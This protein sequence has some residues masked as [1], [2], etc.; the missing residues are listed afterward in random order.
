MSNPLTP[1]ETWWHNEGSAM[2]PLPG[3][4]Y[5]QHA[6]RVSAIAWENG[7]FCAAPALRQIY[8]RTEGYADGAPD[9]SPH[10]RLCNEI[11][12]IAIGGARP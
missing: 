8:D 4:D 6:R 11:S 10:D 7:A 2:S 12:S 9:A 5:E 1:F 3:E